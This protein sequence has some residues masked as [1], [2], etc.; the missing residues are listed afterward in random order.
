MSHASKKKNTYGHMNGEVLA[1]QDGDQWGWFSDRS[2][3]QCGRLRLRVRS[4]DNV[5][6]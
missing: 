6:C 4:L 3:S 2:I 1:V 5:Q